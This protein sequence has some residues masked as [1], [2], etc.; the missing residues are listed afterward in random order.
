VIFTTWTYAAFLTLV[1]VAHWYLCPQRWRPWMLVL[2]GLYFY[3]YYY[4]VHVLLIAGLTVGVYLAGAV[5]E[6]G[7]RRA[8]RLFFALGVALLLGDLAYFKY[9][10]FFVECAAFFAGL[11][12]GRGGYRLPPIAAPL[13]I[14]FFTFEFV[15]Y[16]IEVYRGGIKRGSFRDFSLFI[17]FFPTLVCGPIKRFGNFQPQVPSAKRPVA[18]DVGIGLERILFGIS[19]KLLIADVLAPFCERVFSQPADF[20]AAYL[21]LAMYAYAAQIYFD[22]SGYSDIAIGSARLLGFIVPENFNWPYLRPNPAEFWRSWHISLTAWITD[23]LYFPLGGNRKG[24]VRAQ[25]NRMIAMSLCGLWHGAAFHFVVW[26][27][28]HGVGIN[29]YR[30]YRLAREKLFGRTWKGT[31]IGYAL[32]VLATFHFVCFGW[33]LFVADLGTAL[34]IFGRMFGIG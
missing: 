17:M 7:P 29:V 21:W 8:R 5:V 26:G 34:A 13:A 15:H 2:A 3:Y 31:R 22:F 10:G 28:Y 19:K 23:Y 32:A 18:A 4:P 9:Q 11:V 14:S 20:S 33:I 1:F 24:I 16:L 12:G 25:I 6:P 30:L 27:A